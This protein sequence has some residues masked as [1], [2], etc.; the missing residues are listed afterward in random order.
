MVN[1]DKQVAVKNDTSRFGE[2]NKKLDNSNYN[3]VLVEFSSPSISPETD[4]SKS[5]YR[6]RLF[7]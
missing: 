1:L 6:N 7:K 2:K 4:I 3:I 5:G